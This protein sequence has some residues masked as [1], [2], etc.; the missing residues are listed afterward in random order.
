MKKR[1][2]TDFDLVE[3]EALL[4]STGIEK[5]RGRQIFEWLYGKGVAAFEGMTNIPARVAR[6]LREAGIE[7]VGSVVERRVCAKDAAEKSAARLA[8]G[9]VTE[10]VLIRHGR[11]NTLCLSTQVG[12]AVGCV[13][14]ASGSRGFVRNLTAGEIADQYAH[15]LGSL[16]AGE[17][18]SNIVVM[19]MGEPM[20][21]LDAVLGAVERLHASWG[22]NIGL[23]RITISTVG[24][25]DAMRRLAGSRLATNLAISLHAPTD[26][27]RR[28]LIP[29]GPAVSV[30]ELVN[31]GVEYSRT[32][33][34]DVSVEYVAIGGVNCQPA[35]AR[36]LAKLL[37]RT[38]IKANIIP[39]NPWRPAEPQRDGP[40]SVKARA[41]SETGQEGVEKGRVSGAEPDAVVLKRPSVAE[42]TAF[43]RELERRGIPATIR[44]SRG[45]DV[46]A[47]CGQLALR[48]PPRA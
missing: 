37:R 29:H 9:S 21:N 31:A 25:V 27:M 43:H 1:S 36:S 44:A 32:T 45:G 15:A 2:A 19:G 12:C 28:L 8:D 17:R 18:I 23:N 22:A 16:Q 46:A 14:C 39:F 20:L 47:A 33:G 10:F 35:H 24:Y 13:F 48:T 41:V 42:V 7:P 4:L 3:L 26:D 11:R 6:R 5:Y 38:G 30:G 40:S 34:K